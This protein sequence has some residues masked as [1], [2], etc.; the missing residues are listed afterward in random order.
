MSVGDLF[1][2]MC[3]H[4]LKHQFI[5]SLSLIIVSIKI[6]THKKAQFFVQRK[7]TLIISLSFQCNLEDSIK[8]RVG[9]LRY[10]LPCE[11]EYFGKQ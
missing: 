1:S 8:E 2:S 9:N 11:R 3:F 10:G 5:G 6:L 4:I 7:G